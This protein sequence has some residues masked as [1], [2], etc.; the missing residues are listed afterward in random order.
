MALRLKKDGIKKLSHFDLAISFWV[1]WNLDLQL[2]PYLLLLLSYERRPIYSHFRG[3]GVSWLIRSNSL[4]RCE[5][6]N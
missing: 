2:V 4:L 3:F 1:L 6:L 5:G